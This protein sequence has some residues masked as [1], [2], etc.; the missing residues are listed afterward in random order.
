M[1]T[2]YQTVSLDKCNDTHSQKKVLL[3]TFKNT[4]HFLETIDVSDGKDDVLIQ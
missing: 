4:C 2:V 3:F 1:L